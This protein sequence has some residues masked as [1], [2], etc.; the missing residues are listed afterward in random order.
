[1]LKTVKIDYY[2]FHEVCRFISERKKSDK[3]VFPISCNFSRLHFWDEGF[4]DKLAE[5][6]D[7]F[8]IDRSLL[9]LEITESIAIKDISAVKLQ[10]G[11]LKEKGFSISIDDFGS[12]YSSLGILSEI[13]FDE[14]KLDRSL[15][16][17]AALSETSKMLL[18]GIVSM[19]Q[20][21]NRRMVCEGVEEL[22]QVE[23][24]QS[25]GCYTI[26]GYFYSKPMPEADFNVK[27]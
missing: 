8:N 1:M 24:L 4:A 23:L 17:N 16:V 19:I 22:T 2:V 3:P 11:R 13:D 5:I 21:L 27:Y 9:E 6:A 20:T 26:Q 7:S 10:L 18:C 25:I 15:I 14:I 12:G